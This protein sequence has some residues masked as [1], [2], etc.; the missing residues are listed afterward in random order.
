MR[1]L[2]DDEIPIWEYLRDHP[3]SGATKVA[4]AMGMK[5][6]H[7]QNVFQR[8]MPHGHAVRDP[9]G[10]EAVDL[11]KQRWLRHMRSEMRWIA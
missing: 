7:V 11:E 5:R 10:Y 6:E 8:F 3:R 2:Y 1:D 9:K 4:K